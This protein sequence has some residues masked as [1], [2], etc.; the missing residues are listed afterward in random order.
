MTGPAWSLIV[1][2]ALLDS[3]AQSFAGTVLLEGDSEGYAPASEVR[4]HD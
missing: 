3:W 4:A 1:A 2:A